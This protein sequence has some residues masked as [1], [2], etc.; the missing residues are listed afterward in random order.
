MAIDLVF[1]S[2]KRAPRGFKRAQATVR[3]RN[4]LLNVSIFL[5]LVPHAREAARRD[6]CKHNLKQVGLAITNYVEVHERFPAGFDVSPEG[7]YPG[8]GWNLKILPYMNAADLYHKLEP[9][10]A[11]GIHGLPDT[12]E[13]HRRLPSLWCPSDTGTETVSHAMVV[14]ARVV[15]GIVS[16][17]REDWQDRLPHSSYFGNAG[18]HRVRPAHGDRV[19]GECIFP[20]EIHRASCSIETSTA[21]RD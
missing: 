12:P 6:Q 17:G 1:P 9:H 16:E 2:S 13:F 8:W 3:P 5:P 4:V 11:E 19:A 20:A 18:Y 14:N 15:D 10:F 21:D 7:N